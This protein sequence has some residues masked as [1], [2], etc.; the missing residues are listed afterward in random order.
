[1]VP[2]CEQ[3]PAAIWLDHDVP[4][5]GF[6]ARLVEVGSAEG[7]WINVARCRDC[8][9]VWR[10]DLPD[11]LQVNLAIKIGSADPEQWTAADDR[12]ARFAYLVRSCGGEGAGACLWAGC[13]HR[14]LR[15]VAMCAEHLWASGARA[16]G[17]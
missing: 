9:Q 15:G 16:R 1:M 10:V 13:P 5:A 11:K 17:G 6:E 4:R 14:A 7:G 12:A 2:N 8:G 3:L